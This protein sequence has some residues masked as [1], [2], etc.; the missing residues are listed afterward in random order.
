MELTWIDLVAF[1]GFLALHHILVEADWRWLARAPIMVRMGRVILLLIVLAVVLY[2][3]FPE[4]VGQITE[5]GTEAISDLVDEAKDVVEGGG[6]EDITILPSDTG[7]LELQL[8]EA[9]EAGD[10]SRVAQLLSQGA[11]VNGKG[12]DG[13]T[14]LVV[15]ARKG[16]AARF[17]CSWSSA[18]R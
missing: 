16:R 2:L 13:G 11:N 18:L 5:E 7:E 1:I 17:A 3:F 8:I 12:R 6:E 4:K 14:A 9:A 10:N 15:A